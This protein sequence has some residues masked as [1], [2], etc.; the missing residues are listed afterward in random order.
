M[1]TEPTI[2]DHLD[3]ADLAL[4]RDPVTHQLR[5]AAGPLAEFC[6][7]NGLDPAKTLASEALSFQLIVDWYDIH[8]DAG[9]DADQVVERILVEV[10]IERATIAFARLESA[11]RLH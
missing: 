6:R 10:A 4:Q 9:G 5:F 8:T 11:S 1:A 3:F 2:P 7:C